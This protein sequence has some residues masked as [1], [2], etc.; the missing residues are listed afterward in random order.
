MLD[1][2][3]RS[4]AE[5]GYVFRGSPWKQLDFSC[6]ETAD[7]ALLDLFCLS[8]PPPGPRPLSA[9]KVNL[10]TRQEPVLRAL[11]SG[12]LR[13]EFDA[14]SSLQTEQAVTL[15]A[16]TLLDHTSGTGLGRGPLSN[17]G[18]LSGH[19]L[20]RN[21][22]LPGVAAV[23]NAF[24]AIHTPASSASAT[25]YTSVAPHTVTAPDRNPDTASGQPV[26]WTFS[27][28][29]AEL[30]RAFADV[31]DRK[32]PRLRESILRALSDAGQVRV[33]NLLLDVIVQTG[34]YP[35]FARNA[36]EFQVETESRA[37]V[38]LAIDR[39]SGEILDRQVELVDE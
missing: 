16:Q 12:V 23:P 34:G 19:L 33:W 2:P 32:I 22:P 8:E 3:F 13:D 21:L 36:A 29:S 5:L 14:S 25:L 10:N 37:W 30:D 17:M 7:A 31:A 15:A 6:P 27:G 39:L 24:T 1:R 9:G 38:H 4:V 18:E 11:L 28:L 35:S 20:G 26:A